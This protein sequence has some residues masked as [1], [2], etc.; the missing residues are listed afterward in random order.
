MGRATHYT[1][2]VVWQLADALRVGVF[3]LTRRAPFSQDFKLQGQTEDSIDSVCRNIAEGFGC[4]S[5][6]E[7]ARFLEFSRRSLNEVMD[8]PHS[9]RLKGHVTQ[10]EL[11]PLQQLSRRL[12][13]ALSRFMAYLRK[14]PNTPHR[15]A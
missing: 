14:K 12:Y 2:L 10:A 9:A 8:C 1:D 5:H 7:F 15:Q 11:A 4:E 13:P 3:R 6:K